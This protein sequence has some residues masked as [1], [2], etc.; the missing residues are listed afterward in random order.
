MRDELQIEIN[1][2]RNMVVLSEKELSEVDKDNQFQKGYW[3]AVNSCYKSE[4][5]RLEKILKENEA[6]QKQAV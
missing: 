1:V 3:S 2:A 5:K 4:I 6:K